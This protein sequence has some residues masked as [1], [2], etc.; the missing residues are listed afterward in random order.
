VDQVY[1][2]LGAMAL[3]FICA[4]IADWKARRA[5]EKDDYVYM[6]RPKKD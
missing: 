1:V 6:V 2:F 4:K 3:S 5:V